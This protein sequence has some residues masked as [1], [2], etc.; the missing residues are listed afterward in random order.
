[1]TDLERM[2]MAQEGS[3]PMRDGRFFPY[4][5]SVGKT[6]IGYGHNLDAKGIPSEFAMMLF[7]GD[8]A[9][10]IDAVRHNCSCYDQLTRPRQQVLVSL[11]FNV[12]RE[13]LAKFVRFLGAIHL[14][15][16]DEAA[17]ELLMSKAAIQA[18]TRYG[19]LATMMRE[20]TSVWV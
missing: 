9:D 19:Q 16:W 10:A 4:V 12:G 7:R 3:G 8:I 14:S 18:P 13:G 15:K 6:T 1:M 2:L 5:D 20:N 17:E 11:A